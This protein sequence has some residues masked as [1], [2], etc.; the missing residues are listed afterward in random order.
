MIALATERV[1]HQKS[2]VLLPVIEEVFVGRAREMV[3]LQAS[4]G[5][6][7]A[8]RG[9]LMLLAGEPGI[10]KTRLASELA[11]YAQRCNARVLIGRCFE[12]EGTPPFWP[13]VQMLRG[14]IAG[15]APDALR[16]QMG[17]GAADIAQVVPEVREWLPDVPPALVLEPAQARFR[18]FDSLT[19]F[20]KVAALGQVLVL[21][22][23]DLHWADTPSLLLLQ[24]LTRALSD[25][26]MLVVA[27]Y[28]DGEVTGTHPLAQTVGEIT[29]EPHVQR[30]SLPRLTESDVACWLAHATG[31]AVTTAFATAVYQHTEGNPFFLTEVIRLQTADGNSHSLLTSPSALALPLPQRVRE[32]LSCRLQ[33]LSVSCHRVLTVAAVIGREF[34]LPV[35]QHMSDLSGTNVL[36]ALAEALAAHII[37]K[38]SGGSG[39]Y[40]FGHVLIRETLYEALSLTDRVRLHRAI[41]EMLEHL[42]R[43]DP[44][45]PPA[46]ASEPVLEDIAHHFFAA[47]Q[48]GD[49]VD[50][51]VTYARRA[52]EHAITLLAYEDAVM[53]Y[54]RALQLLDLSRADPACRCRLLL[55][56]GD[57]LWR[58]GA[59]QQAWETFEHVARTAQKLGAGEMLAQAALGLGMVRAETGKV[60]AVLVE[61]LEAA[62]SALGDIVSALH[63]KV[64][65]RLAMALYFSRT[66]EERN[67]LS[68]QAL[69]LARQSG[70]PSAL[71]SALLAR[72]FVLWGP[73]SVQERLA[74]AADMVSLATEAGDRDMVR[75]GRAWKILG[76][77]ELGDL[78]AV[79]EEIERY[80]RQSI[81]NP[82]PR[83]QW[84]LLLVQTMRALL[85]GRF[86]QSE[87]MA[88]QAAAIRGE[89]G[90]LTNAI[91][92]F[93][94]QLFTI[95]REQGRLA[96]LESAVSAYVQQFPAL[97]IWRCGLALLHSDLGNQDAAQREFEQVAA[98]NFA[99]LPRDA[100][101][102]PSLAVL[103][104]VSHVLGDRRRAATL[105]RLLQPYAE[106]NVVV[107]T[108]AV[109][110]GSAARYLGLLATTLSYWDDARAYFEFAVRFNAQMGA[111]P[112][113]A[114]TQYDYAH[115]LFARGEPDDWETAWELLTHALTTARILG[116]E[117]LRTQV[118]TLQIQAQHH[119]THQG[120]KLSAPLPVRE[121]TVPQETSLF[122]REGDYWTIAYQDKEFR[123]KH[124]RGLSY[125]ATLL[126]HP[127]REFPV[128]DLI[129]S[130]PDHEPG[131]STAN[132][133]QTSP[134]LHTAGLGDAG[135]FLDGQARAAYRRRLED[136]R[137]ELETAQAYND[138]ERVHRAQQ[139]IEFL[140]HELATACGLG[141]RNRKAASQAERARVNV[142]RG[143]K[144]A[145]TKIAAHSPP[146]ARYLATTLKTG[147]FC[148][149]TPD[150]Y[151]P[152]DWQL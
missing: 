17:V 85:A 118:L 56:L 101:W 134:G 81:G 11:T 25:A 125:I 113:V 41:G 23:D 58:T 18:F 2:S 19:N 35:L 72:H 114:H 117:M 103:A 4:L 51:A 49:E 131:K 57:A 94:V 21:I 104:E 79:D 132:A 126:R 130:G 61:L 98:R 12:G 53:H 66:E 87:Q 93:A 32:V 9:R 97:P 112:L 47:A 106:R 88:T 82:P 143:I 48:G 27:T 110:Y 60:D 90:E 95:R 123:L 142:T 92:F 152:I 3:T 111:S 64:L 54:E 28:R 55:A 71:A 115:M 16:L 10:G 105:Y 65:A 139:E 146:L 116:M 62:H 5:S 20:F 127:T 77:L 34:R 149:F 136:L 75:E 38:V 100:N 68:V 40:R 144:A 46:A 137:D 7:C 99:D 102:L 148:S 36:D 83:Y 26:H 96:E 15:A 107:A 141:G 84:H 37:D 121:Q 147:L 8:G 135:E 69:A 43:L 74:L 13:W 31:M 52:A 129:S 39:H 70:D 59:N 138:P 91:P 150:P 119:A 14:Y 78:E 122:H 140:T 128:I 44:A 86:D 50:K 29:Q 63:A 1:A 73:G 67:Q 89:G 6:A 30:I 133:C 42:H 145:L 33:R 151:N 24:F 120:A 45:S 108:S 22:L 80:A 109:C 124:I 76:C